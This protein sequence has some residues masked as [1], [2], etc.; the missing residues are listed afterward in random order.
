MVTCILEDYFLSSSVRRQREINWATWTCCQFCCFWCPRHLCGTG[1]YRAMGELCPVE[2][3]LSAGDACRTVQMPADTSGLVTELCPL[4][5][6][7]SFLKKNSNQT[8]SFSFSQV[9]GLFPPGLFNPFERCGW[10]RTCQKLKGALIR[11]MTWGCHCWRICWKY[12]LV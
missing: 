1:E 10:G 3:H 6:G 11:R 7:G 5:W 12:C 2:Q 9:F 4:P 8:G